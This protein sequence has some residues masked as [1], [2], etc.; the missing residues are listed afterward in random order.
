MW[1]EKLRRYFSGIFLF[2]FKNGFHYESRP[3][4]YENWSR[5]YEND[6][7]YETPEII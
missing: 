4:N 6:L 5:S 3:T 2:D 7:V 1:I